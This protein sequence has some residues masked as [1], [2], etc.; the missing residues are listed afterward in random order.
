VKRPVF[1]GGG[2]DA[3]NVAEALATAEGVIVSTSILRKDAAAN[4]PI[5]WDRDA[6]RRLVEALGGR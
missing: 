1:I 3:G 6:V 5:R 4:D 2:V